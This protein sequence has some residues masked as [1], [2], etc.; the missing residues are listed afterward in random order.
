M[1]ADVTAR[2]SAADAARFLGAGIGSG[3]LAGLLI[4]GV[5]GRLAMFVLRLTSDPDL[6]GLT[7][8]DGFTVGVF[9]DETAFLLFFA[10][11]TG[12]IGGAIYLAVRAW[13]PRRLRPWT[14]AIGFGAAGAALALRPEGV[15]FTLLS[16]I[17]LAVAMFVALPAGYGVALVWGTERL[18]RGPALTRAPLLVASLLPL[19]PLVL[20]GG[21]GA[22]IAAGAAV[23]WAVLRTAPDV[24]ALWTSAPVTWLGRG[25]L[26]VVAGRFVLEAA[27]EAIEIL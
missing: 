7:T 3:F 12:A 27:G 4:G 14:A 20:L 9:S 26:L 19:L 2:T 13:I 17:P 23:A 5:G 25:L 18:L 6:K 16:P 22:L 8:D 21:V 24:A 10:A 11:I 1:S 15:D